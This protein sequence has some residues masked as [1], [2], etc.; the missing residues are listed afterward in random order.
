MFDTYED[1]VLGI[2]DEDGTVSS[3]YARRQLADHGFTLEEFGQ[4][5]GVRIS[6]QGLLEWL[7]Y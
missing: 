4:A 2:A 6:A 5:P 3:E 1:L 7:G